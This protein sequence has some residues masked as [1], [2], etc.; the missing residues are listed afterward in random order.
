MSEILMTLCDVC[1]E[2]ID[3]NQRPEGRYY[4]EE[5]PGSRHTAQCSRCFQIAACTQYSAKSKA[6]VAME[7]E[8]ARQR[9]R[10]AYTPKHDRRARYREPWRQRRRESE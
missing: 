10:D 2:R 1:A 4:L 9:E 7:R 6:V 8:L 3:A 5:V